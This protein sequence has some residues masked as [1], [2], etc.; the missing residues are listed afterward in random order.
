MNGFHF[1]VFWGFDGFGQ[2]G[3]YFVNATLEIVTRE[4]TIIALDVEV[5]LIYLVALG[6]EVRSERWQSQVGLA[7]VPLRWENQGCFHPEI[8][9][10]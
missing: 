6:F 7:R 1:P 2:A 9:S 10:R 5:E 3:V 4:K 8:P